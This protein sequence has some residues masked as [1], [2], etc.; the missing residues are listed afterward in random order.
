MLAPEIYEWDAS[1][2]GA[3]CAWAA[4]MIVGLM[5]MLRKPSAKCAKEEYG[6]KLTNRHHRIQEVTMTQIKGMTRVRTQEEVTEVKMA[7]RT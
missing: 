5:K 3:K 6:R 1:I 4:A 2:A 7:A